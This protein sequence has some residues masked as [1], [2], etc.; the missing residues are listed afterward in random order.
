MEKIELQEII[1]ACEESKSE[2]INLYRPLLGYEDQVTLY[3]GVD[4]SVLG[5]IAEIEEVTNVQLPADFFQVYLLSNGGKYFDVNLFFLTNDKNDQNGIYYQNVKTD[6]KNEY[7]LPDNTI[8]IGDTNDGLL[9][10][11]G[12]DEEGYYYYSM[13]NK[14]EKSEEIRCDY[15]PELL[16][17]EIDYHTG[18]FDVDEE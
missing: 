1:D 9:V 14:E 12:V 8:V 3:R 5:I 17:Y 18:N 15:L 11:V 4:D 2:Y 10:I 7:A 6:V 13:W 16:M